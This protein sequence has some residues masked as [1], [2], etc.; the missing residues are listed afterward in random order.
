MTATLELPLPRL[1]RGRFAS[2][3]AYTDQALSE[4]HALRIAFTERAGGLSAGAFASLNLGINTDDSPEITQENRRILM[5]SFE[6]EDAPCLVPRQVHGNSLCHIAADEDNPLKY[7]NEKN[8]EG[9]DAILIEKDRVAALLCF[10][11][12]VPV[13]IVSP[14]RRF[15]V[16]HAGWRGVVQE[17][18]ASSLLRLMECDAEAGQQVEAD[19]YNIYIGPYIHAE[20]FEVSSE[21]LTQFKNQFSDACVRDSCHIDLAKAIV[22][23]LCKLGVSDSRVADL[24]ICTMCNNNLFFSYRAQEGVCGRHG[25]FAI[26][27]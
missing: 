12:C 8:D 22:L 2:I 10:A 7:L 14:T 23:S 17:I 25:A 19:Q 15:V 26:R 1:S 24:G 13:I 16:V 6:V 4:Q 9:I 5:Q 18:V 11:D 20:C 3:G 21:V 27:M